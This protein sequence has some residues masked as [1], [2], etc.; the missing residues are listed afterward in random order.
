MD[1]AISLSVGSL[2]PTLNWSDIKKETFNLPDLQFQRDAAEVLWKLEELK[3]RLTN[4]LSTLDILI[5]SRFI[6]MFEQNTEQYSEC[7]ISEMLANVSGGGTPSKSHAEYYGGNIPWVT[8]KDVKQ[9]YINDSEIHIT[10]AGLNN[11]AAKMVP[12]NSIILVVRSGI[13]KHTLPVAVN[14][15]PISINQDLKGLQPNSN[16]NSLFLAHAIKRKEHDIIGSSRA[17]TVDNVEIKKILEMK[18][19]NPPLNVQ[20]QFA[21][22]VKQV[23]KSKVVLL[24]H[25]EDTKCLQQSIINSCFEANED[26]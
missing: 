9:F 26:V 13:L 22:F 16:V 19:P 8:S 23:D 5:K 18:I 6:E 14:L 21:D 10:E 2:S 4:H 25:I 20:N 11:S 12:A 7:A 17:T 3:K 24:K 1:R 15:R